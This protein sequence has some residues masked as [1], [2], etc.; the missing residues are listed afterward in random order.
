MA[1]TTGAN[2]ENTA[3]QKINFSK[4]ARKAS[5]RLNGAGL[6]ILRA[7]G[8][9]AR[10]DIAKATLRSKG[11]KS[12]KL[13]DASAFPRSTGAGGRRRAGVPLMGHRVTANNTLLIS[14][15]VAN[16]Y[17]NGRTLRDGSKEAG[18]GLLTETGNRI[19]GGNLQRYVDKATKKIL[20]RVVEA[21]DGK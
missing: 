16:L 10:A 6:R 8:Y 12:V 1:K 11:P 5:K 18:K 9:M 21:W 14:S 2:F 20:P 17:N 13:A 4:S 15:V 7:V 19:L 3:G